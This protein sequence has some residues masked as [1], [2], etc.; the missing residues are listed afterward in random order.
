MQDVINAIAERV[1]AEIKKNEKTK[2]R[3]AKEV[4]DLTDFNYKDLEALDISDLE[5]SNNE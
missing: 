4:D 3:P 5:D 2:K 1:L